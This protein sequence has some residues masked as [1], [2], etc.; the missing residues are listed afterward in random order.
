MADT[1]QKPRKIRDLKARLG[2]TI[3]PGT[4][5]GGA[6]VPA[7]NLG[8]GAKPSG[9][10]GVVAPP[11]GISAPPGGLPAPNLGSPG[12]LVAPPFGRPAAP[13]SVRPGDPFGA[14]TQA[15]Q[16]AQQVHLVIDDKTT[17]SDEE[18]GRKKRGKVP[19][20]LGMGAILG[21]AIGFGV[22]STANSRTT[23]RLAAEDGKAIYESVRGAADKVN[24]AK[25][26]LDQAVAAM[27][28][29][30]GKTPHVDYEII[31]QLRAL[32]KPF[33]AGQFNR[34]RYL[35][36]NAGTVDQLFDYYAKV[37]ELWD[38][39]E[40]IATHV[41]GEARHQELDRSAAALAE[42]STAPTGCIP[43]ANEGIFSCALVFV[44]PPEIEEGAPP[45][46]TAQV[47]ASRTSRQLVEKTIYA[48]QDLSDNPS[49]YVI[50]NDGAHSRAVLGEPAT[51]FLELN[52]RL[53]RLK[54]L[55]D[56]T[57]E[58]QGQLEQ[59]LGAVARLAD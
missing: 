32:D 38:G 52:Q 14:P 2:R 35:A 51:A 59:G 6:A 41:Q 47:R 58:I 26:L 53:L 3:T 54:A 31:Q 42:I 18:A 29:G 37:G 16:A 25:R 46:T 5:P 28:A 12:G 17:V 34:R 9:Q 10:G 11:A 7:P 19:L 49:Q 22:G 27:Q 56:Q 23:Y 40:Q 43:Q 20:I 44:Q 8:G 21:L 36:F 33:T 15:A 30:P 50:L 45:P 39:F 13:A 24:E 4:R 1:P 57:S 48:G 55:M